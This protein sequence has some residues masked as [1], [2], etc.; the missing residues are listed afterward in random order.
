[1]HKHPLPKRKATVHQMAM[2]LSFIGD[3]NGENKT[4]SWE[5]RKAL[6]TKLDGSILWGVNESNL[7]R[8]STVTLHFIT[9]PHFQAQC[10]FIYIGTYSGT[11]LLSITHTYTLDW[12]KVRDVLNVDL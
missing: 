8:V 2:P 3:I 11:P 12:F 1:M 9:E 5:W 4:A 10:A 6:G 7:R